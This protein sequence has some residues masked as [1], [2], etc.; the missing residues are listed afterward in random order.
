M[1]SEKD[2]AELL[3][4]YAGFPPKKK[5]KML[6]RV[7]R[8]FKAVNA[9]SPEGGEGEEEREEGEGSNK[10]LGKKIESMSMLHKFAKWLPQEH[11]S[12]LSRHE[13]LKLSL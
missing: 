1:I 8:A 11:F 12:T 7:R 9:T 13:E 4:A 6:K 2:F 3:I 10:S 5:V